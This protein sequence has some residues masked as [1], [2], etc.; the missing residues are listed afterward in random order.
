ME[1]TLYLYS[2]GTHENFYQKLKKYIYQ[3]KLL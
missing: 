1:E 3:K 2:V